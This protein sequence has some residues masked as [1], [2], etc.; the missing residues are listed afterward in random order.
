MAGEE[1]PPIA[2]EPDPSQGG[3]LRG[4]ALE[5]KRYVSAC[6]MIPK[7]DVARNDDETANFGDASPKKSL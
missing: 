6:G 3:R 5:Q 1:T 4:L 7:V 2:A